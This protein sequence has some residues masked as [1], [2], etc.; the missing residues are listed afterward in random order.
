MAEIRQI[1][2]ASKATH[3]MLSEDLANIL[4]T[5]QSRNLADG[6]TGI[7]L[8]RQGYFLQVLEGPNERLSLLL[9]KLARDPRHHEVRVLLE[10]NVPARAF[11]AWSMAFQ[12]VSGLDPAA[13]PGYSTFL[14]SGFGSVEC[15][16]YPH[17]VLRMA[18]AFRD[19]NLTPMNSMTQGQPIL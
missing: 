18:L 5:A 15:V 19:A 6:I 9:E 12:D 13:M 3:P 1:V 11:G 10:G 4:K 17:K 14:K 8:Y 16:R 2:Y 7:L